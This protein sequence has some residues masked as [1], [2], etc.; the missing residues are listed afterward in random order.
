M[1]AVTVLR[2]QQGKWHKCFSNFHV[3]PDG[4]HVEGEYQA[5]KHAGHPIRQHLIRNST[6]R[7]AKRLGR[8]WKLNSYQTMEWDHRKL[9]VMYRLVKRKLDDH[10]EIFLVLATF[11]GEIVEINNWHD[12]FWGDCTCRRCYKIG[13]N[14]L[15]RIL[16]RL[17][18]DAQ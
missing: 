5:E 2:G 6:P 8:R 16:M 3:E 9:Q 7:I 18:D 1:T 12:N 13:E 10:P 17:R 11:D 4:T 14:H 15:G